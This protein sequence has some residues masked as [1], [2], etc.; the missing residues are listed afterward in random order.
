MIPIRDSIRSKRFPAATVFIVLANAAVFLYELSLGP[1]LERAFYVYGFIPAIVSGKYTLTIEAPLWWPYGT[2]FTSMF[3]HGGWMHL[4]GNMYFLWI[5][6]SS[7]EDR[8]GRPR[9]MVFYLC[10][11]VGAAMAHYV[12][13]TGS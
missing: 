8:L 3:F 2:V 6:G 4:I 11:G 12:I 1:H 7:V 13:H 10:A 9:F 5:F